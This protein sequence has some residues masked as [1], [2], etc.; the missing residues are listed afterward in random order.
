MQK[1]INEKKTLRKIM[2]I[3]SKYPIA[4]FFFFFSIWISTKFISTLKKQ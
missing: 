1:K 2:N 4:F 3:S